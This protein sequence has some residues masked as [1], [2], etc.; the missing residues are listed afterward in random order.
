MIQLVVLVA[1]IFAAIWLLSAVLGIFG[2]IITIALWMLAGYLAGRIL[3]GRGY[4]AIGN[5]ALGLAGGI[6]GGFLLRLVGLG[7]LGDVWLVGQILVG[8]V[9]A[10][11]LISIVRLVFDKDFAT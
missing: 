2:I 9:G 5:T 1:L 4:G 8:V 11:A 3:R 6:V 7:G 10:L